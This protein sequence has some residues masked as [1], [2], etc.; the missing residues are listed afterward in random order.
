MIEFLLNDETVRLEDFRADL[1]LLDYL[2]EER[3]RTG[4]KEGCASGDCGACTVVLA[5]PAGPDRLR[6]RAVNSCI[7]FLGAVHARQVLTVEDLAD[8]DSLHPVQQ[9]MVEHHASQ[10]GFCTPGFVMSLFA[11]YKRGA[12]ASRE[13]VATALAG[14]LCRCTGYRPIVEAG[15][16]AC[17]RPAPDRFSANEADVASRLARIAPGASAGG[18]H[19]PADLDEAARL[20][21][22]YPEARPFCGATDLALECTV[23]LE[24][25]PRLV[26][27]GNVA[28][29][30]RIEVTAHALVIGA[31]AR[32]SDCF[33]SL[34]A[35]YPDLEEILLRL[36]SVP[37]RNQGSFGGNIANASPI[38]DMPPVL[39]ALGAHVNVR[40]GERRRRVAVEE[41]F[42]GYRSTVLEP[43]E[44][45]VSVEV[46]R[47]RA[48]TT[49]VA[50]KNSKRFDDDI[51]TVMA[52]F[53]MNVEDGVLTEISA[54]FGGMAAT[55]KRAVAVECAM[56][57]RPLADAAVAGRAAVAVDFEPI[58]DVRAS[59]A[60][61]LAAAGGLVERA[62]L[63]AAG[64]APCR[65]SRHAS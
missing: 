44:F 10:C 14:N 45:I 57:G 16:A 56:R 49:L 52:A 19:V 46:P 29:L 50:C 26:W 13:D 48:G 17:A 11:L 23:R 4:T 30:A 59:A 34:V 21:A 63:E 62:C 58:D 41:F 27:L 6:Y 39:I 55:P 37:I 51:S 9:A 33:E 15:L 7:T 38:G 25:L 60:Y 1:T 12:G 36:G 47:A 18:F 28:E 61:R 43:G 35:E 65:V 32:Y 53:A 8:G 2:R 54:A 22:A 5:E 20:L 64:R 42:T 40:R 24:S 3:R 31:A